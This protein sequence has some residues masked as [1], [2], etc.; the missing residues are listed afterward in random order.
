M[1]SKKPTFKF[2]KGE[3]VRI[4]IN[5]S[6]FEKGYTAKWTEEIF[7]IKHLY[8]ENPLYIK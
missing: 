3:Q 7:R 5:K 8:L 6:I 4:S 2:K 1:N